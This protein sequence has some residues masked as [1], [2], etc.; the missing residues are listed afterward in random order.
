LF[1]SRYDFLFSLVL[2]RKELS[3]FRS[4]LIQ[5]R[6]LFL[7]L[8]T[9]MPLATDPALSSSGMSSKTQTDK[10]PSDYGPLEKNLSLNKDNDEQLAISHDV[11]RVEAATTSNI[12]DFDGPDDPYMPMNWPTRKK[13]IITVLYSLTT[14]VATWASTM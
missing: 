8:P 2:P 9:D 14:M 5:R 4:T 7:L 10:I 1:I 12:V 13:V 11:Q 6:I 3:Y